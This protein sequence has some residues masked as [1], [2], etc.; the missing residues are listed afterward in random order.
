LKTAV[1]SPS[2]KFYGSEQTLYNFLKHSQNIYTVFINNND[3]RLLNKVFHLEKHIVRSFNNVKVLYVR[4]AVALLFKKF[5][6]VYCNEGGHI[7]Y[8]KILSR[9]FP[10]KKFFVHI[11]LT[12]D[13]N[14]QRLFNLTHNIELISVS[15]YISD[16]ISKNINIETEVLSSP[17]RGTTIIN[18]W[19]DSNKP[20][21]RIGIIGRVTPSKG[22]NKIADLID[23]LENEKCTNLEFHFF[24]DIEKTHP[25]VNHLLTKI[26]HCKFLKCVFHGYT[27][28]D[29]IYNSIDLVV[30]LNPNEPHG[31][32]FFEALN[33][34]KPFIGFNTGGI[35]NIAATLQIEHLMVE[36]NKKWELEF[37]NRIENINST[38]DLYKKAQI[39]MLNVYSITNYCNMLEAK[40]Y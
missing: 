19:K 29:I 6:K 9:L 36:P 7:K 17:N 23:Y 12:E 28:R 14:K 39:R 37:L 33:A 8:I 40:I 30:H 16:L 35:G 20:F 15:K 34:A 38:I 3:G 13:T 27:E 21:K 32:I 18:G 2:G 31:V 4:I 1:I 5:D 11:R 25:Q 26:S 22:V 10:S 24:G